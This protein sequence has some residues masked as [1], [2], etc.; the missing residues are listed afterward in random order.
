[1]RRFLAAA[2]LAFASCGDYQSPVISSKYVGQV[3]GYG[4]VELEVTKSRTT[5]RVV[6][7]DVFMIDGNRRFRME[8]IDENPDFDSVL[9]LDQ[10]AAAGSLARIYRGYRDFREYQSIAEAASTFLQKPQFEVK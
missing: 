5:G 3:P 6:A 7:S 10:V 2:V 9:V 4:I 8:N 1:M